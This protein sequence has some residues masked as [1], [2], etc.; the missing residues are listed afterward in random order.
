M[1]IQIDG[2]PT[3]AARPYVTKFGAF[4]PKSKEKKKVKALLL[5]KD[6]EQWREPIKAVLVF[7]LYIPKSASKKRRHEMESQKIQPAKKPDLDNLVKFILDCANGIL[8]TDDSLITSLT[9]VKRYS[10]NPSTIIHLLPR[11]HDDDLEDLIKN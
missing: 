10:A 4:D 2:N 11:S 9:A 7:N 3:P 6:Y 8:F 1:R 5:E